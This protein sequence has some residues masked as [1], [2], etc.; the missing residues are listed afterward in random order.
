MKLVSFKEPLKNKSSNIWEHP[1]KEEKDEQ[2]VWENMT[3]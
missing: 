3:F 1:T 2:L